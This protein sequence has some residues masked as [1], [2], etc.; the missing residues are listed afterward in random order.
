LLVAAAATAACGWHTGLTAPEHAEEGELGGSGPRVAVLFFDRRAEVVERGLEPELQ[1]VLSEVLSDLVHARLVAP[2]RADVLVRGRILEYRRRSGIRD[3]DNRLL[4]SGVRIVAS[5]ELVDARSG[6]PLGETATA[7]V[8]S[9]YTAGPEQ[10]IPNE[11]EA[12]D[13]ALRHVAETLVLKLFAAA[14]APGGEAAASP[15]APESTAAE[16]LPPARSEPP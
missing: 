4:E 1:Q 9:G 11:R 15:R 2:E 14:P 12:R 16:P 6:E 5:A 10:A 8:W 3:R 7:S 13:R